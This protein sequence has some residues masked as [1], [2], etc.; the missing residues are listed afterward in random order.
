[1][2]LVL[3][4]VGI[5]TNPGPHRRLV[6]GFHIAAELRTA[7]CSKLGLDVCAWVATNK[8]LA[9]LVSGSF[10][11]NQQTTLLPQDVDHIMGHLGGL[12]RVPGREIAALIQCSLSS[13][14]HTVLYRRFIQQ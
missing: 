5:E 7:I 9:K 2:L 10:K 14:K 1:M 12:H 8:L 3:Y 11:P 6:V 13:K 4:S